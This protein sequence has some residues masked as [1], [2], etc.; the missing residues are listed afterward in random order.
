[1]YLGIFSIFQ[2][3]VIL[4]TNH[5]DIAANKEINVQL[6]DQSN[7]TIQDWVSL[8]QNNLVKEKGEFEARVKRHGC[9]DTELVSDSAA[10]DLR[11]PS[12][13]EAT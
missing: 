8:G 3:A 1:M 5:S 7:A 9:L 12:E 10:E 11:K 6:N 4:G 13:S 2:S